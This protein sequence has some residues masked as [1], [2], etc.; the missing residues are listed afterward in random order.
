ME[1]PSLGVDAGYGLASTDADKTCH[2]L[3]GDFDVFVRS[4]AN[5]YEKDHSPKTKSMRTRVSRLSANLTQSALD[6]EKRG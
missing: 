5:R 6:Q 1:D 3:T 4:K 2:T